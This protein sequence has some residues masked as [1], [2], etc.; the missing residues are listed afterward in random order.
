MTGVDVKL[1]AIVDPNGVGCARHGRCAW[2]LCP[3]CTLEM[4]HDLGAAGEA[5][6]LA[7]EARRVF[8]G[9][10]ALLNADPSTGSFGEG[11]RDEAEAVVRIRRADLVR[12]A[13]ALADAMG[14]L[15]HA[16]DVTGSLQAARADLA[17]VA[18]NLGMNPTR[19][20]A[21]GLAKHHP[22]VPPAPMP[23]PPRPPGVDPT[24]GFRIDG[25]D[26]PRRRRRWWRR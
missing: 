24:A 21:A 17:H 8:A 10:G 25:D 5:P 14:R 20:E 26:E 6:A 18:A 15:G 9:L 7:T 4:L 16:V 19:L 12:A 1:R 23:D 3:T 13:N 11:S 22:P 2:G